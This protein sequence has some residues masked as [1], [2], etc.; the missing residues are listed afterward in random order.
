MVSPTMMKQA[1]FQALPNAAVQSGPVVSGPRYTE[2]EKARLE[3]DRV[4]SCSTLPPM[5]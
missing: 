5:V 1:L 4:A 2:K 3:K